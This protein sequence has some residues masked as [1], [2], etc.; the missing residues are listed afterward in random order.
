VNEALFG[1]LQKS[2]E[3]TFSPPWSVFDEIDLVVECEASVNDQQ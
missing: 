2:A 1:C 3:I